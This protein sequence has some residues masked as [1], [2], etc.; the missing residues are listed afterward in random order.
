MLLLSAL[1]HCMYSK[2][3]TFS[4]EGDQ[5]K[6]TLWKSEVNLTRGSGFPLWQNF[7]ENEWK[8]IAFFSH[9]QWIGFHSING[10]K[11]FGI[12]QQAYL[13]S[14]LWGKTPLKLNHGYFNAAN[15]PPMYLHCSHLLISFD[16]I[17]CKTGYITLQMK[18]H[19][20]YPQDK[21]MVL[22]P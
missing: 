7:N 15:E 16:L 9:H 18:C 22:L 21:K 20:P 19:I 1:M 10:N 14:R 3:F 12:H 13:Y 11:S 2:V 4:S 8:K 6:M 5:W 17:F